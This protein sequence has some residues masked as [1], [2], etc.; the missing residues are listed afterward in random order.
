M[1]AAFGIPGTNDYLTGERLRAG[2]HE[3][4]SAA[5]AAPP[6]AR[7][8]FLLG[9]LLTIAAAAAAFWFTPA[10]STLTR[11]QTVTGTFCGQLGSPGG[12][13]ISITGSDGSVHTISRRSDPLLPAAG[14][15]L[16]SASSALNQSGGVQP[17]CAAFT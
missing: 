8:A 16:S 6:A 4:A 7:R 5:V 12:R 1:D 10:A 17:R 9:L 11:V 14:E 13:T 2:E 15:L 3:Q